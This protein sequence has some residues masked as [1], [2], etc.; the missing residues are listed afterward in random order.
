MKPL[1]PIYISGSTGFRSG[2][3][4]STDYCRLHR[5]SL[6]SPQEEEEDGDDDDEGRRRRGREGA[7]CKGLSPALASHTSER[8]VAGQ[9][10]C[11]VLPYCQCAQKPFT[12]AQPL[13]VTPCPLASTLMRSSSSAPGSHRPHVQGQ[14]A[15]TTLPYL[16]CVQKVDTSAQPLIV[17]PCPLASTLMRSSSSARAVGA[18]VGAGVCAGAAALQLHTPSGP[19]CTVQRSQ[20]EVTVQYVPSPSHTMNAMPW[21][22]T[23]ELPEHETATGGATTWAN[24]RARA[25]AGRG[26]LIMTSALRRRAGR[27]FDVQ[28]ARCWLFTA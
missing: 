3:S 22:T 2:A 20:S 27:G 7:M 16:P 28:G 21:S 13:I 25:A 19:I 26:A 18:G 11:I 8:H 23:Q 4:P 1:S 15:C 24:R 6:R 17:T 10:A 14:V 5:L 12:S 9:T